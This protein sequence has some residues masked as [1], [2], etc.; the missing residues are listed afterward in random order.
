MVTV[1]ADLVPEAIFPPL[2]A[3]EETAPLVVMAKSVSPLAA[4]ATL[5]KF[6]VFVVIVLTVKDWANADPCGS[7]TQSIAAQV[8]ASVRSRRT[9][10]GCLV[11]QTL[12]AA[13]DAVACLNALSLRK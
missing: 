5:P 9:G 3:A 6:G 10:A 1:A 2:P 4:A 11:G 7:A 8:A 13:P 12:R